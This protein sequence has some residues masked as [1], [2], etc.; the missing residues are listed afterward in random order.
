[1]ERTQLTIFCI[2]LILGGISAFLAIL[3]WSKNRSICW[4]C[5]TSSI[6]IAYAGFIYDMMKT[7]GMFPTEKILILDIP[8]LTLGFIIIPSIFLIIALI[9]IIKDNL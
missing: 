2:K 6:L 3:L 9:L 8:I 4:I 7:L 5:L 1:M